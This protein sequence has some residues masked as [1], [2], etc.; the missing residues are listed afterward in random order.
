[1]DIA[2]WL[3]SL[4]LGQY[5][6]A[7]RENSVTTDLLP[8]LTPD[9]LKD[10]GVGAVGH[11]RRL[12]DAIAAL[13]VD[14]DLRQG[15]GRST[16]DE[17]AVHIS[18]RS[19]LPSI[20]ERRQIS[21]MFCD[22][23]D[24]TA[25]SSRLDPEDLSAVIRGYQARVAQTVE[26]FGGFIARY[27]GDG[28]LMYFGWPE[29]HEADAERAVC[30]ALAVIAELGKAPIG[31]ET[32]RVRIGIATGLVVIGEPIGAGEARQQTAIGETPNLAARLQSL[33][34]ANGVVVDAATRNL[35]RSMF[36]C[37]DFGLVTLKGIPEPVHV[38][39]VLNEAA[40]G[41][42]FE[43]L[44]DTELTPLVGRDDELDL[45]M[46]RWV[47][48]KSGSGRVVMLSGEPGIGKSRLVAELEQR[49]QG[50]SHTRLRYFCSA[51]HTDSPLYP[52]IRQLALAA[53]FD[54]EDSHSTK[55]H[56]LR[57]LLG[58]DT[59][60]RDVALLGDL[61]ALTSDGP[62]AVNLS[63]QLQKERTFASLL[64]QVELLCRQRPVLMIVEDL[65]WA[66][67]TT[68]ELLDLTVASFAKMRMLLVLTFRPDFQAPW[69][70]RAGVTSITL[71]RLD[72][73][74]AAHLAGHLT[75]TL[76]PALLDRIV[77]QAD[78]VPLFIEELT[79]TVSE[80][81][82][83][84]P[85]T[86]QTLGVPTTL[87]GLLLA[88]LDRLPLA[89]QA[90]QIGA[91]LG[92]EFSYELIIEVANLPEAMLVSGLDQ[93][94]S[95][96]L[97]HCRGD[98]PGAVYRFKHALVQEAA[99]S[100]L[101]R[102]HRQQ[103]HG[104]IADSLS[105]S[106]TVE[107]QIL[108]HHLTEAG[109]MKEAVGYWL[110]AGK[111]LAGR[112]AERE[113]VS[114][115]RRGLAALSTLP[116]GEERDQWELEFYMVLGMPLVA[117]EGYSSDAVRLAYER[118]QELGKRIG[119]I[120]SLLI[121]TYGTFVASI[122]RNDN[123]AAAQISRQA[124][125]EFSSEHNVTCRLILHRMEGYAALMAGDLR[126]ARNGME[127]V[128][129]LYEPTIHGPLAGRWGHDARGAVLH[130]LA[131]I[132][133]MLGYPD[134]ASRL[135]EQAIEWARQISH[136]GNI[137]QIHFGGA[138][139]G[140]LQRDPIARQRHV[141]ETIVFAREHGLSHAPASFL[142]GISIFDQ[143]R[144]ADGLALAEQSFTKFIRFRGER[145]NYYAGRLAE[146]PCADRRGG[147]GLADRRRSSINIRKFRRTYL[148][149]RIA[150]DRRD[151][152]AGKRR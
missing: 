145:R 148:G 58:A 125:R 60:E 96:G 117:T 48:M 113:T 19:S 87:Q 109:R 119:D 54:R 15:P 76:P 68:R 129:E 121:G 40:V 85:A 135:M 139:L 116:P 33:A 5:E 111:N 134:Q 41:S 1:M 63:S 69:T 98:P 45:L 106:S 26:R 35:I 105:A 23:I 81:A 144:Q 83:D 100:T 11:R 3:R 99:Y 124:S 10:L 34:G 104:R 91:V 27:V 136:S 150:S 147:T 143:G 37:V 123:R 12:L 103:V 6:A 94:V 44:H 64:R 61:L 78:G 115:F 49:L 140:D 101:L 2:D 110:Q 17:G 118:V 66:D 82:L 59:E 73:T 47:Q 141:D 102:S 50:E 88:R 31:T 9:D 25:L 36:S 28:V 39:Q 52:V 89:K 152:P 65:H 13:R 30:A 20:G 29:A 8:A 97:T 126:A 24:F 120:E 92:R 72:R 16:Q 74:E 7:F 133:W 84:A 127:A 43:A 146:S 112:A 62:A 151:D 75:T 18:P 108:A 46:R 132:V 67:P 56:K 38:W 32:L 131:L 51:D 53:G 107:L 42:R 22:V 95:S 90:A 70:G 93:L 77:D 57:T 138:F 71:S 122:D 128:V 79:K 130:Y 137:H 149:R 21:V 55:W 4:G 86:Q 14:T 80:R 114:L 142:Q